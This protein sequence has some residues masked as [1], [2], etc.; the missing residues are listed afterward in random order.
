MLRIEN[1]WEMS[2]YA[3]ET[4]VAPTPT[5]EEIEIVE[6]RLGYTL[7]SSYIDFMRGQNGGIPLRST[8]PT[9]EATS[10]ADDHIA[11]TAFFPLSST[12]EYGIAGEMGTHFWESEWGYPAIG[13][14]ICD[15][16]SAGHDLVYLDYR[17]CGPTGEPSV[18]H[19]DVECEQETKL[20]DN[21][22]Q[23]INGLRLEEEWDV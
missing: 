23:F 14:A 7:P 3:T 2:E 20:A 8:Y 15:C 10:W 11:I 12:H 19:I 13:V 18:V 5:D 16:P 6:Q 9:S 21:F 1:F 22:E 17:A 4:Y